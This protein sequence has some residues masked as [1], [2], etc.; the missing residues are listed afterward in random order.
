[1][2]LTPS[3]RKQQ[4]GIN[5]NAQLIIDTEAIPEGFEMAGLDLSQTI[6]LNGSVGVGTSVS[7]TLIKS[8]QV[9]D[10]TGALVANIETGASLGV[11]AGISA[12][13][14]ADSDANP[15]VSPAIYDQDTV[16]ADNTATSSL[17]R[18]IANLVGRAFRIVV[19]YFKPSL[20]GF[21]TQPTDYT[22][23]VNAIILAVPR[24]KALEPKCKLVSIEINSNTR[25]DFGDETVTEVYH[26]IVIASVTQLDTGLTGF[27]HGKNYNPEQIA[28]VQ[29]STLIDAAPTAVAIS[30][31]SLF[32][33]HFMNKS[34]ER[35]TASSSSSITLFGVGKKY[36]A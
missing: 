32:V 19:N 6:T 26:D 33:A 25:F 28:N 14:Y 24:G 35:A 23:S 30:G 9:Y 11:A 10:E 2:R 17:Y 27:T 21:G 18:I 3:T 29:R 15:M 5:G 13:K 4:A 22:A 1:M 7:S 31:L 36:G 8:V 20:A 12:V 34:A 16:L